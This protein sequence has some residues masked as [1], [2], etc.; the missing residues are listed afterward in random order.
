M[1]IYENFILVITDGAFI[2]RK[3]LDGVAKAIIKLNDS[4]IKVI[5][6]GKKYD[7]NPYGFDCPGIIHKGPL[8]H[9]LQ[10]EYLNCSDIFVLPTQNEGCC[11][12]IVEALAIV[13]LVISSEGAFNDDILNENNSIRINPNDVDAIAE[14][15]KI[16]KETP[17]LR[18]IISNYSQSRHDDYYIEGRARK[19]LHF[20]NRRII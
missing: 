13:I 8:N 6:I 3:G 16:L 19:I 5:F 20:I 11:N 4:Q 17:E 9:N 10:P 1:S 2:S 14:V 15:I 12:A 18:K 7:G